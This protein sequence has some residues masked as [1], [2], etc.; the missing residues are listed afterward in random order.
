MSLSLSVCVSLSESICVY[1]CLRVS[2]S[3]SLSLSFLFLFLLLRLSLFFFYISFFLCFSFFVSLSI[4]FS[5][6]PSLPYSLSLNQNVF[7]IK[8][9]ISCINIIEDSS[10]LSRKLH[11][12]LSIYFLFLSPT[13]TNV[14]ML[15]RHI[16]VAIGVTSVKIIGKYAASGVNYA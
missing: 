12:S 13:W 1:A 15:F 8:L 10:W 3:L 6:F 7:L 14:I 16:Y 5:A 9:F 4:S 11:L 2:H